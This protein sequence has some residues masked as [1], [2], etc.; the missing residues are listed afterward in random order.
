[1]KN[2]T[3]DKHLLTGIILGNLS[4]EQVLEDHKSDLNLSVLTDEE[5]EFLDTLNDRIA[6]MSK[7]QA[8]KLLTL[9]ELKRLRDVLQ[10]ARPH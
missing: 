3:P 1:M 10:K 8:L 9:D 7:A 6:G 4:R 2:K 5:L